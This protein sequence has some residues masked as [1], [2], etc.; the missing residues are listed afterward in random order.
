MVRVKVLFF[1][2][3]TGSSGIAQTNGDHPM[4]SNPDDYIVK[5]Y[6]S[7]SGLPQNSAKDLLL[8]R[9]DFLWITTENGLVRF[10]GQQFLLQCLQYALSSNQPVWCYLGDSATGSP[11]SF[12]LQP[13]H[14][15]Q[16]VAR[17][18]SGH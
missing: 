12:G 2:M 9:N 8:D 1:L 7:E 17:L 10:D 14:C 4:F 16:S 18:P 5:Q 11:F 15:L 3:L 6:N 13:F